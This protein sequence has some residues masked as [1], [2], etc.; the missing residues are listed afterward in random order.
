MELKRILANDLRAATEKAIRIYGPNTLV[1]SSERITG[2][3]EVIVATDFS[4]NA[5]LANPPVNSADQQNK[6]TSSEK[7]LADELAKDSF[8]E[9]LYDSIGKTRNG[10]S[11]ERKVYSPGVTQYVKKRDL[12][13]FNKPEACNDGTKPVR[14]QP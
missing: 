14:N 8:D 2:G 11:K 5:D 1:V 13:D 10:N 3:V 12:S 9:I 4:Q 7:S 6:K